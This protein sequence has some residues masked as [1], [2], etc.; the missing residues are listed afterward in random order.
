MK[1]EPLMNYNEILSSNAFNAG[2]KG[3]KQEPKK[4]KNHKTLDQ[5]KSKNGSIIS[6][7]T[8]SEAVEHGLSKMFSPSDS[9]SFA[10]FGSWILE[11]KK[12]RKNL[13]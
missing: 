10:A 9:S 1:V 3:I 13:F 6:L 12:E 8:I 4:K 11:K 2:R 5:K 7:S